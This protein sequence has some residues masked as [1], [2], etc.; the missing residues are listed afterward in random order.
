M[1]SACNC[2]PRRP[3]TAPPHQPILHRYHRRHRQSLRP[4]LGATPCG[5]RRRAL[6]RSS[7]MCGA[8]GLASR[9]SDSKARTSAAAGKCMRGNPGWV[10]GGSE[11]GWSAG[12]PHGIHCG[13]AVAVVARSAQ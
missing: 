4:S 11:L 12:R 10:L 1:A 9:R 7:S 13:C 5:S 6:L 3:A 2:T 8:N